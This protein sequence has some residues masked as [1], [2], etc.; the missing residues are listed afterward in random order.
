MKL[1]RDAFEEHF[2][3]YRKYLSSEIHRFCDSASVYRQ[4][5]ERTH[6]Y[7]PELNLAPAFF[8][9]V[10][11]A[12]FTMIVLWADK[13]F[14]EKGERG[15]FNFLTLVEYNRD[16]MTTAELQRR[17]GYVDG[18]WML[19]NRTPITAQSI[20]HDRESIRSLGILKS[21]R[22]RRD[23]FHGHFDKDYFFDRARLRDEAPLQWKD[24]KEATRMIGTMLN[25]YSADFDGEL[26]S[27]KTMNIGDLE[28]L[29]RAARRGSGKNARSDRRPA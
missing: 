2:R 15:L 23:K 11:D 20:Q 29:L 19:Q 9:T 24:L 8:H 22:I 26:L 16:W 21:V 27:W 25:A 4:I 18:H 10:E 17:R 1:Q 28:H 5:S 13:L 6:D 12:L 14:D 3:S 7:L